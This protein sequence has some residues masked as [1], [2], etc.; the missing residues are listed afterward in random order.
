MELTKKQEEGLNIALQRYNNHEPYTV[1]A[2]YAGSGKSTLVSF[3]I[4]ALNIDREDVAYIA[5][6]GKASLVLKEKGCPNA[7]TAHKLLYRCYPRNDGTFV[8]LPRRPLEN[9]YKLIVVDEVSMLPKEMWELLLSHYIHVIALG[10][11]GQ[12]PPIGE[13]NG[14][15]SHPHIFLDE[16]V[17]QAQESEIIRLSMDIREGKPLPLMHGKEVIIINPSDLVLGMYTWADQ[18]LCGKNETRYRT[19]DYIRKAIW[20]TDDPTPVLNDKVVCGHNDWNTF[21]NIEL[22][23]LV[24]GLIGNINSIK[25]MTIPVPRVGNVNIFACGLDINEAEDSFDPIFMDAKLFLEHTPV[26]TKENFK[27]LKNTHIKPFEYAY[28]ITTHKSQGSEYNKV[29]VLEEFLRGGDHKRWLYTACTRAV[30]K[31]VIVR[32]Y[33]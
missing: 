26:V 22:Q 8:Y 10:D 6:T 14:I 30:K 31:L 32:N 33:R 21:S 3:I 17:R 9:H 16:I 15:L 2:G 11:P 12:L 28:C 7:M 1:I 29:L 19:N 24:N 18:V 27:Y 23:P 20:N 5:Y 25:D 13:D 4:E